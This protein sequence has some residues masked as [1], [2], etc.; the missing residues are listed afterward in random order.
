MLSRL[1]WLKHHC[2]WLWAVIENINNFFL[3]VL[4]NRRIWA[5]RNRLAQPQPLADGFI[6]L[7]NRQDVDILVEFLKQVTKE[8]L[9]FFSPHGFDRNNI[10]YVLGSGGYL[11]IGF[12]VGNKM[13]GY[14]LM[15]LLCSKKAFIGRYLS[16][17]FRRKGLGEKMALV[18]YDIGADLNF[19]VYSTISKDNLSSLKSHE[20]TGRMVVIK[21]MPNNYVL[22][23]FRKK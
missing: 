23:K 19:E 7:L 9:V 22:V 21:S 20:G 15:R 16:S 18:L 14:F 17:D 1:I 3:F 10:K 12:F 8:E 4:W 6:R 5:V 2:T 11:P 13:A